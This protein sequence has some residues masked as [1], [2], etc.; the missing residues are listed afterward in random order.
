VWFIRPHVATIDTKFSPRLVRTAPSETFKPPLMKKNGVRNAKA[1]T[2]SLVC[3]SRCGSDLQNR[4]G[5]V[6]HGSVGSTPA[7]LR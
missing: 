4:R 1:T 5:R 7:P 3:S 6:T 2:R